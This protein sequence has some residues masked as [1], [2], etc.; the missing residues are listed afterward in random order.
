MTSQMA[1]NIVVSNS[2]RVS[3][4]GPTAPDPVSQ[5]MATI[6]GFMDMNDMFNIYFSKFF[7]IPTDELG[8]LNPSSRDY[9]LSRNVTVN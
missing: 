6:K 8:Y 5:A 7:N 2:I 1:L 4:A 3:P 9:I